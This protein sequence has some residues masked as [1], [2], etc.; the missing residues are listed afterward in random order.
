VAASLEELRELAR[1]IHPAVLEHGLDMAL[2]S[3]ASRSSIP[4]SVTVALDER[5]PAPVELAAYFVACEAL[6]N[7]G[8]YAQATRATIRVTRGD[9]L[10]IE[11]A[12]DGVGGADPEHGSGLRGLIDRVEAAGGHLRVSSPPGAG[13]VVTADLPC[14]IRPVAHHDSVQ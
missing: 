6:A 3:L 8:K 5:L 13:T 9:W 12:D 2:H 14:E 11:V 1:G 4:V 10:T 7:I